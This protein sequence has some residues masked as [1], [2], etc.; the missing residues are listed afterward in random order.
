MNPFQQLCDT[1]VWRLLQLVSLEDKVR[2][3]HAGLDYVVSESGCNFSVGER[4]LL[5]LARALGRGCRIMLMDE[6]TASVDLDTDRK[7]QRRMQYLLQD[8]TVITIAHRLQT[9]LD[10]DRVLVMSDGQVV[11]FGQPNALLLDQGSAFHALVQQAGI[12][13]K[14][15]VMEEDR[16]GEQIQSL[17]E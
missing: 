6:A 16:S 15:A 3:L 5:C 17:Y 13:S 12:I 8:C 4:Q 7:L 10:S 2:I 11:E 9:V 14:H 1:E